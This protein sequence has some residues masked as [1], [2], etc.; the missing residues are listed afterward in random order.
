[1]YYYQSAI[2]AVALVLPILAIITVVLRFQTRLSQK[3]ALQL[4]DWAILAALVGSLKAPGI[5][6]LT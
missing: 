5:T 2:V 6:S 4:D 1:M 3:H